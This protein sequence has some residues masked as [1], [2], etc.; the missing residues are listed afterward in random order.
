MTQQTNLIDRY[1]AL[2]E[3]YDNLFDQ[4]STS[5][6]NSYKELM[7]Q[8]EDLFNQLETAENDQEKIDLIQQIEALDNTMKFLADVIDEVTSEYPFDDFEEI[9]QGVVFDD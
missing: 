7:D 9:Y 4:L 5:I 3:Q 2:V 6:E 8:Y 1:I